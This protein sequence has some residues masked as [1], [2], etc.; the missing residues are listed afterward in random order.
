MY[1]SPLQLF[2]IVRRM[3]SQGHTPMQLLRECRDGNAKFFRLAG[4]YEVPDLHYLEHSIDSALGITHYRQGHG[5]W[6][7]MPRPLDRELG[8][9]HRQIAL[10]V[11]GMLRHGNTLAHLS[12]FSVRGGLSVRSLLLL[13]DPIHAALARDKYRELRTVVKPEDYTALK[14]E[15]VRLLRQGESMAYIMALALRS[16]NTFHPLTELRG[17]ELVNA[18]IV[19][20]SECVQPLPEILKNDS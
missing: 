20:V 4:I 11:H 1:Q 17:D 10:F 5:R 3:L 2:G 7:R 9:P 8:F 12:S 14:K 16:R 19:V 15:V 18:L 13:E 6:R